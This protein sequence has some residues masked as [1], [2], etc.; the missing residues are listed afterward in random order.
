MSDVVLYGLEDVEATIRHMM[1][2]IV[3]GSKEHSLLGGQIFP[4]KVTKVLAWD[5]PVMPWYIL[6]A[7]R[8][9]LP[10][11]TSNSMACVDF[12]CGSGPH[13]TTI[14]AAGF[15]YTGLDYAASID[16]ARMARKETP[17]ENE[18]VEYDGLHIPFPDSSV[19]LVWSWSS[20]EHCIDPPLSISEIARIMRPGGVF[21]GSCP[22]LTP[23]HAESTV[24]YTPYGFLVACEKVGLSVERIVPNMDALSMALK[25]MVVALGIV[26]QDCITIDQ[27]LREDPLINPILDAFKKAGPPFDRIGLSLH[28]ELCAEFGFIVKKRYN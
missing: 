10:Q 4:E 17:F 20:I 11:G 12:G 19:D 18:V 7:A 28:A 8:S 9:A 1:R 25:N 22:S 13:R 26:G 6:E 2:R 15:R 16:P 27:R 23:Y 21:A 3:Q 14:E 24:N 5:P